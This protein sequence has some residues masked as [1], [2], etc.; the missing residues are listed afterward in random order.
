MQ[1]DAGYALIDALVGMLILS[2]AIIFSLDA[3]RQARV[4]AEQAREVSRART[5]LAQLVETGPRTFDDTTGASDD[6]TWTVQTRAT[7]GERPIEVCHRQ[8]LLT[9]IGSRRNYQAATLETCPIETSS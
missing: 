6:F 1:D 5:L 2:L 9:N 3:G 4:A 7:G 8:V